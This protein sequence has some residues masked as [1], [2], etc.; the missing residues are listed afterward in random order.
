MPQ[1]LLPHSQPLPPSM[2][3]AGVIGGVLS[4]TMLAACEVAVELWLG[5]TWSPQARRNECCAWSAMLCCAVLCC[6]ALRHT[7]PRVSSA[8]LNLRQPGS[9]TLHPAGAVAAGE[10]EGRQAAGGAL[11]RLH[12]STQSPAAWQMPAAPTPCCP[13][14]Q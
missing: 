6:A 12:A 1:T 5:L 11:P 8:L 10:R 7:K 3:I 4:T 14:P 13:K 2:P 9:C